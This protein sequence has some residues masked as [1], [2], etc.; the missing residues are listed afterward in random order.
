MVINRLK[1]FLNQLAGDGEQAAAGHPFAA[2]E[3]A[4]AVLLV[5]AASLDGNIGEAE[6]ETIRRLVTERF[7]MNREEADLLFAEAKK[8]QSNSSQLV[9]FTKA[10]KDHYDEDERIELI[11]MLWEVVYADRVL[12]EYESN[13]M[14]RVGG[15]IYVSD[16]D[17]GLA[18]KRVRR[19]LGIDNR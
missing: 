17:R 8:V 6:M 4:A 14:R 12:H 15:L 10:V 5:E 3:M 13:L 16:R 2:K 18:A 9:R 1:I 11:E 19:R 7:E